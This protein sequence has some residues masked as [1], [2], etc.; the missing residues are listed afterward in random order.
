MQM[1]DANAAQR[2]EDKYL[3]YVVSDYGIHCCIMIG[4]DQGRA[5]HPL[6]LM[7]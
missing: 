5:A 2:H 3:G 7:S 4:D 6:G 1:P